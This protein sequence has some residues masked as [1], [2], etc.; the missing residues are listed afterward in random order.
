L[1]EQDTPYGKFRKQIETILKVEPEGLT[2]TEIK[3]RLNLPQK[4]PNNRWVRKMEEDIGL[5]RKT[6][7]GKTYWK[8]K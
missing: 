1:S 4:V 8:L 3:Q 7:K 2:W 5:E 6:I